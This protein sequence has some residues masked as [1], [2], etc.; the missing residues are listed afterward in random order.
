MPRPIPT[1][2]HVGAAIREFRKAR[3]LTIEELAMAARIDPSYLSG[4]ERKQRNPSWEVIRSLL[5]V[6]DAEASK[7]VIRAEE[8]ATEERE[9]RRAGQP[10]P[11]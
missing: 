4:I 3:D 10:K 1:A 9:K 2:A 5:K 6:L 8:L 7:L 11:T